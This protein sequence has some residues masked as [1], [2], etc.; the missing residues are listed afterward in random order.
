MRARP[1]PSGYGGSLLST[2]WSAP[3]LALGSSNLPGRFFFAAD[4]HCSI[5][6]LIYPKCCGF[7]RRRVGPV[8]QRQQRR[9]VPL[10]SKSRSRVHLTAWLLSL[11]HLA[12][13]TLRSL[14]STIL[15]VSSRIHGHTLGSASYV[16]AQTIVVTLEL[17]PYGTP[18]LPR[19]SPVG[20]PSCHE[21]SDRLMSSGP[22][23]RSSRSL[24]RSSNPG[25]SEAI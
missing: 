22:R 25:S 21:L 6:F 1:S 7:R 10:L 11:S 20:L 8:T 18:T 2:L 13:Q 14:L 24:A 15:P 9:V 17:E 16:Y 23:R 3:V 5:F 19:D 4:L 12:T